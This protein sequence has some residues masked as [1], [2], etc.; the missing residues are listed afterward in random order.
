MRGRP[1]YRNQICLHR[2]HVAY[3]QDSFTT[4]ACVFFIWTIKVLCVS[5]TSTR[6]CACRVAVPRLLAYAMGTILSA[7]GEAEGQVGRSG[8]CFPHTVVFG[9]EKIRK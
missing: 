8:L 6:S 5:A 3:V 7:T 1:A 9:D 4:L 2:E